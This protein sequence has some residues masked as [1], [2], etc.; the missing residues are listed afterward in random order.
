[1]DSVMAQFSKARQALQ[2]ELKPAVHAVRAIR[3]DRR[4]L[5]RLNRKL[6]R[7]EA[8]H[9]QTVRQVKLALAA[10]Q[11]SSGSQSATQTKQL[12]GWSALARGVPDGITDNN[13]TAAQRLARRIARRHAPRE[14][15]VLLRLTGLLR[16]GLERL[17]S[18]PDR[19]PL[20][21]AT[22]SFDPAS[23]RDVLRMLELAGV[24]VEQGRSRTPTM[25]VVA[26]KVAGAATNA[27]QIG[28]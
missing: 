5:A 6:K 7:D 4:R 12:D 1:M 26:T 10:L 25:G 9:L 16:G 11:Q 3:K 21:R 17:R 19:Q 18:W 20:G 27:K 8:K 14:R 23:R 28:R 15:R 22:I 24:K 2:S 13:K